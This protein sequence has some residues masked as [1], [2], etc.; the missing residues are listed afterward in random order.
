M[1]QILEHSDRD[2]KITMINIL[3]YLVEKVCSRDGNFMQTDAN[4]S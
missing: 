1:A 2:F 4:Y 3:K